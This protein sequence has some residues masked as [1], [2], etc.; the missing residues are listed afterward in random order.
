MGP[1]LLVYFREVGGYLPAKTPYHG[2]RTCHRR[3]CWVC[4]WE[5]Y[6]R[7]DCQ[8]V[9]QDH[10][11][12][13]RVLCRSQPDDCLAENDDPINNQRKQDKTSR[14]TLGLVYDASNNKTFVQLKYDNLTITTS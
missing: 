12:S 10:T 7:L 2:D 8:S 5:V 1:V 3:A 13:H 6:S 9:T 4:S 11:R 14:F